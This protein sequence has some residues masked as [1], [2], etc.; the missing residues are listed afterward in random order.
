MVDP[1]YQGGLAARGRD[2][3]AQDTLD[4]TFIVESGI[5]CAPGFHK[6]LFGARMPVRVVH[7]RER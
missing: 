4:Q 7:C 5:E 2:N 6:K 3:Q 1:E